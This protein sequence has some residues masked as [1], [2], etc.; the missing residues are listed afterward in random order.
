MAVLVRPNV[1]I[2]RTPQAVRWNDQLYG[3][4][5]VFDLT[6]SGWNCQA[7]FAQTVDV[8]DDSSANF[9][10]QFFKSCAGGHTPREVWNI[11]REVGLGLFNNNCVP[12]VDPHFSFACFKT[13]FN[14]PTAKSSL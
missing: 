1:G 7:I 4:F 3:H 11:S 9:C 13:L 14:V 5:D 8:E 2:Q 10:F 6:L 12:H